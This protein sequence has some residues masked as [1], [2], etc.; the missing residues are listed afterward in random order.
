MKK[1]VLSGCAA[2]AALAL[3]FAAG[4]PTETEGDSVTYY[5]EYDAN[6]GKGE[7]MPRD[8]FKSDQA[9]ALRLNTYTA[10]VPFGFAGW[11]K[12]TNGRVEFT[13]GQLVTKLAG[14]EGE[15]VTL[16]AVWQ[17]TSSTMPRMKKISNGTFTMGSDPSTD[18]DQMARLL[19]DWPETRDRERQHEVTLT[20][21]FYIG[22]YEVTQLEYESIMKAN[23]STFAGIAEGYVNGD[24]QQNENRSYPV[25]TVTWL[26]A[27]EFCNKLSIKEGLTQ[28]YMVDPGTRVVTWDR[29]ANGYRLPTEAEWE[30]ACRAGST[31]TFNFLD[32]KTNQYGRYTIHTEDANVNGG[33]G[34]YY[35]GPDP[36]RRAPP[37]WA[38]DDEPVC[39]VEVSTDAAGNIVRDDES[40]PVRNPSR[41]QPANVG[42]YPPNAWGLYDM[43][44]NVCELCWDKLVTYPSTAQTDPVV[45]TTAISDTV[46]ARGGSYTGAAAMCRAG[47]RDGWRMDASNDAAGFRL[48]RN[49]E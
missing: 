13:D 24:I 35:Y 45:N 2:L 14:K 20:K 8:T 21:D 3:L 42:S 22:I 30:Y 44:G 29:T 18:Y 7:A 39:R 31:K 4:C 34:T 1:S 38:T 17:V 32:K 10:E 23:P 47:F 43:H 28:V 46:T 49:A 19:R 37:P 36:D 12:T 25:E 26:Q 40:N 5:I 15:T 41:G 11:S 33:Y 9:Q 48:A 16:Y 6:G 27:I